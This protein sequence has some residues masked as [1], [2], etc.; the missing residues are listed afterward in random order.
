MTQ[1]PSLYEFE[2]VI[3]PVSTAH[4]IERFFGRELLKLH[5][6]Q[7]G[8][9]ADLVSVE[10]LDA[11]LGTVWPRHTQVF[12][13]RAEREVT[14][15]DYTGADGHIDPIRLLTLFQD[16][17]TISF[18]QMQDQLS[19]LA[20]LCRSAEQIFS[21]PFQTNLYFSPPNAQ[22]F[23]THHD[24]HDVFVLQ[25]SGSKRWR[26]YDAVIPLPLAG[27]IFA[28][29][30]AQL[31]PVA[32]EFVLNA[33]DLLYCPRG[34]PHDAR[35]TDEMS[36]H[37]TLGAL[38]N[39]WAEVM[40]EAMAECCLS[41]PRF[42]EALP[43]GYA[44]GGMENALQDK[45]EGL[46]E[47]FLK[48]A[49]SE[50]ALDR[51]AERFITTR[52]PLV[53]GQ[54]AQLARL[55]ELTLQSEVGCRPGLIWRHEEAEGMFKIHCHAVELTFPSHAAAAVLHAVE[56]PKF[57]VLDLPGDLDDEGRLVLIRRLIREGLVIAH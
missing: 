31:G 23:K 14:E 16:G 48:S 39:T 32:D 24:T 42:R 27:Q 43:A 8:Y 20:T 28:G 38:V 33:G 15:I 13:V 46:A 9:F 10:T 21:C 57:Q 18:R 47:Q 26:I 40:I 55:E 11:F 49:R 51:I 22:G 29:N 54:R 17:A 41:D 12:A 34:V 45:F 56:T 25:V 7:P 44:A 4:F 19:P 37:I 53:A 6:T 5:R 30:E 2:R 35:S 1:P 50:A 36:L 52:R 3:T